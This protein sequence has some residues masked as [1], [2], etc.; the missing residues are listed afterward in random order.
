MA[1]A[2]RCCRS[3]NWREHQPCSGYG[4]WAT[5]RELTL[6]GTKRSDDPEAAGSVKVSCTRYS[7]RRPRTEP[8]PP[9][10]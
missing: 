5:G 8:S 1:M 6:T 2:T 9:R 3:P 7:G 4:L 10:L